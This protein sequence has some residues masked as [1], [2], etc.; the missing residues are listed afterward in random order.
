M[1]LGWYGVR[2]VYEHLNREEDGERLYE[3]RV[4]LIRAESSDEA[5]RKAEEEARA[6]TNE[7]IRYLG[8]ASLFEMFDVPGENAEVYSLMRGDRL[9]P[10]L[11]LDR[12]F[13]TGRER[14]G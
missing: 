14:T 6:Y 13:D 9:E 3:E 1:D 8:Y 11:Y 12:F 5:L 10:S 7:G 4:V 2:T